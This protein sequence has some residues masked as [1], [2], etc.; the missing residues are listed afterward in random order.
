[1]QL[2]ASLHIIQ[3]ILQKMQ[4]EGE[5][6]ETERAESLLEWGREGDWTKKVWSKEAAE[7]AE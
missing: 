4:A 1:M 3:S 6:G 5:K 2:W 7:E